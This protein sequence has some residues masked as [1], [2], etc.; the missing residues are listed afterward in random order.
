MTKIPIYRTTG[1]RDCGW[2]RGKLG[3]GSARVMGGSWRVLSLPLRPSYKAESAKHLCAPGVLS[4][5]GVRETLARMGIL[6]ARDLPP[7]ALW[8]AD[9]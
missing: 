1:G 7:P 4:S 5:S 2:K 3:N 6:S 9:Y 8:C